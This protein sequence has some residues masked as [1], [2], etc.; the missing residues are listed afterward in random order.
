[1]LEESLGLHGHQL[2]DMAWCVLLRE[3]VK[4]EGRGLVLRVHVIAGLVIWDR[5]KAMDRGYNVARLIIVNWV[6]RKEFFFKRG[7]KVFHSRVQ[8][9][10]T[11]VVGG[12]GNVCNRG[13]LPRLTSPQG[14]SPAGGIIA[15]LQSVL[16]ACPR[17][18]AV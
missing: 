9:S 17:L 18:R 14:R 15:H 16:P 8:T 3:A 10:C 1:M 7:T 4:V 12:T 6:I 13:S 5:F 2:H 11:P